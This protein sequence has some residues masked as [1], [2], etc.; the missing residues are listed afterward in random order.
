[1]KQPPLKKCSG[2]HR[3]PLFAFEQSAESRDGYASRCRKCARARRDQYQIADVGQR[4]N[5]QLKRLYGVS[6]DGF[7]LIVESQAGRCP[8]CLRSDV[9][10]VMDH[11][12]STGRNRGALCQ[13]CNFGLGHFKDNSDRMAAA[14]WYL[15]KARRVAA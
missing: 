2:C 8:I 12:H 7:N 14:I 5:A 10:M 3:L 6:L 11:D 13:E 15:H 1:M 9:K 4:R